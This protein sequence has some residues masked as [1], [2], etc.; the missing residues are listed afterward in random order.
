MP[1]DLSDTIHNI[2]HDIETWFTGTL[3]PALE[4]EWSIIK[5]QIIALGVTSLSIVWQAAQ[6]YVTSGGNLGDVVAVVLKQVAPELGH[7]ALSALAGAIA[8]LQAKQAA[9][10]PVQ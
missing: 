8:N 5:P 4:A 2:E 7:I 1:N 9:G 6:T 10:Q 3:E